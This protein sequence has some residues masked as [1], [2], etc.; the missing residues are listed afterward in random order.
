[1]KFPR[2]FPKWGKD[3][4][5]LSPNLEVTAKSKKISC[6]TDSS[7]SADRAGGYDN[8]NN[9]VTIPLCIYL[10][11]TP[12][13]IHVSNT[14]ASDQSRCGIV[15]FTCLTLGHSLTRLTSEKKVVVSGMIQMNDELT[16]ARKKHRIRGNDEVSC[17]AISDASSSLSSAMITA[18]AETVLSKLIF[19]LSSSFSSSSSSHL[20]S[21][22]PSSSHLYSPSPSSSH[23]SSS[24]S[25]S[26]SP[27]SPSDRKKIIARSLRTSASITLTNSTVIEQPSYTHMHPYPPHLLY[28]QIDTAYKPG[29][30]GVAHSEHIEKTPS[31]DICDLGIYSLTRLAGTSQLVSS[32]PH[33]R[34]EQQKQL[35]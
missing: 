22:S 35:H 8:G 2:I 10:L 25:C 29:R 13:E 12:E 21:P 16:F 26:F 23:S 28:T 14:E 11:P 34:K 9:S 19:F 30:N 17:W 33:F 7:D 6:V 1:M 3:I 24:S 31:V 27:S 32:L 4:F 15:Q 5:V 20:S 18:S